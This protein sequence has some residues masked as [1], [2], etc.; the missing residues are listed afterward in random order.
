MPSDVSEPTIAIASSATPIVVS[1][2]FHAANM[3]A[4]MDVPRMIAA[5]VLISSRPFARDSSRSGRISGTMPYFAGLKNVACSAS[6]NSTPSSQSKRPAL[7][8]TT[9][10]SHRDDFERLRDD[11]DRALVEAIGDLSRVAGEQQERQDEDDADGRQLPAAVRV[12]RPRRR[13][14]RPPSSR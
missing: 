6:R 5:N 11:Q 12:R 14:P 3:K 4:P 8:A 2:S 10:P 13:P 1:E 7:K 9:A